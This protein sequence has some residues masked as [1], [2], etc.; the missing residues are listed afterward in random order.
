VLPTR[1]EEFRRKAQECRSQAVAAVEHDTR[2]GWMK[3]ADKWDR[4]AEEAHSGREARALPEWM[5]F[6]RPNLSKPAG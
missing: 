1:A 4:M 3:L 6:R 2:A 5:R